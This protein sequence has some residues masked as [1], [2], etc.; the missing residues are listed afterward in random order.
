MPWYILAERLGLRRVK[1]RDFLTELILMKLN[2]D[3]L[4]NNLISQ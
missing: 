4:L 2:F 1:T 3:F